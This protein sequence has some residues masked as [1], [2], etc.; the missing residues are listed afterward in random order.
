MYADQVIYWSGTKECA[1]LLLFPYSISSGQRNLSDSMKNTPSNCNRLKEEA[2]GEEK[3]WPLF[4]LTE[5]YRQTDTKCKSLFTES[6]WFELNINIYHSRETY[7]SRTFELSSK[8]N[9]YVS[10]SWGN[11]GHSFH[12]ITFQ[13]NLF[14]GQW[15]SYF[16]SSDQ[17]NK[18][19]PQH[20]RLNPFFASGSSDISFP[21][22]VVNIRL[23]DTP[24]TNDE[25]DDHCVLLGTAM[26]WT[27]HKLP[28]SHRVNYTKQTTKWT[29]NWR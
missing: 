17:D 26:R 12:Q 11:N 13:F 29:E 19:K 15:Q 3:Q 2:A 16:Y 25:D 24:S 14:K 6:I 21:T 18:H 9:R 5:P 22:S 8:D 4:R 1:W 23:K 7:N 27:R 10:Q 20:S 28:N